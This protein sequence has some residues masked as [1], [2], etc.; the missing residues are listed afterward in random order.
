MQ[1]IVGDCA[2]LRYGFTTKRCAQDANV[3]RQSVLCTCVFVV[4]M[5]TLAVR[6]RREPH[7]RDGVDR[8]YEIR[9]STA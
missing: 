1:S 8:K 4:A 9:V 5:T 3:L 2:L 7:A 6:C